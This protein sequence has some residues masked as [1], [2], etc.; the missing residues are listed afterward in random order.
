MREIAR[1]TGGTAYVN[2]NEIKDGVVV[3]MA[4]AGASYTLGYYPED[5]KWDGKY[6]AIKVK[7]NVDGDGA[8][9]L[10]PL[11]LPLLKDRKS[12]AEVRPRPCP[13]QRSR[14]H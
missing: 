5:K 10:S 2:Q 1:E 12:D 11:I 14:I 4:D 6:R 7:V 9:Y 13:R 8:A 3:A